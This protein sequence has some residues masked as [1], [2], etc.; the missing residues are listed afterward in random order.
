MSGAFDAINLDDR[1]FRCGDELGEGGA[2]GGGQGSDLRR[3]I[4]TRAADGPALFTIMQKMFKNIQITFQKEQNGFVLN[5]N[6][7]FKVFQI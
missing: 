3:G 7:N 1:R 6:Y 2:V 5:I 4:P